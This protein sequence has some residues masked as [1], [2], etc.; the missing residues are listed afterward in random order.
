MVHDKITKNISPSLIKNIVLIFIG[1]AIFNSIIFWVIEYKD[2]KKLI[3][4]EF[5]YIALAVNRALADTIWNNNQAK[6]LE[7]VD[8]ILMNYNVSGIKIIT[9]DT[10]YVEVSK[11]KHGRKNQVAYVS[12]LTT[13]YDNKQVKVADLY[14]YTDYKAIFYRTKKT[15]A[16]VILKFIIETTLLLVLL[17]WA[18]KKLFLNYLLEIERVAENKKELP[19]DINLRDS[20]TLLEEAFKNVLNHILPVYFKEIEKDIDEQRNQKDED[21]KNRDDST[22]ELENSNL[23]LGDILNFLNPSRD[24]IGNYFNN[25]F[26]FS[27][28]V[29]DIRGDIYLFVEIE[30]NRELLLI[31]ID[32][33]NIEG[34]NGIKLSIALKEVEKDILIKYSANRRIFSLSNILGFADKKIRNH[35]IENGIT[36]LNDA[37]FRGLAIHYD[38]VNNSIEYS[39]KGV[40]ILKSDNNGKFLTYDDYGLYNDRVMQHSAVASKKEHTIQVDSKTSLYIVTD[41][42]FRQVKRDKKR[43]EIG[44]KGFMEVLGR[45]SQEDFK[46]QEKSFSNEFNQLKGDKPQND[47]VTVIGLKFNQ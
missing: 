17:F 41:G 37:E 2:S 19:V 9:S 1:V 45:V 15:L 29:Q 22:Q 33:G 31:I 40:I 12:Q 35:F 25:Y 30:K 7:I 26:I 11:V 20:L 47:G 18:F 32:Y 46:S 39:S 6:M 14:L 24:T 5:K 3:Y 38:K 21:I 34:I 23:T 27:Q 13:I 16:L 10:K 28:P 42:F 36:L 44:K 43:E 4:R 8:K